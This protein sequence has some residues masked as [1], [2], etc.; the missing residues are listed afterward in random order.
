MLRLWDDKADKV[1]RGDNLR[2]ISPNQEHSYDDDE[3]Y[4]HYVFSKLMFNNPKYKIPEDNLT[5]FKKFL[6][7]GSRSYP[8]DGNIPLDVVSTEA[9]RIIN[10]IVD[11]TSDP[12]HRLYEQ[13]QKTLKNGEYGIVRG[14][15][16]IYL[17]SYTTRDWRRKRFTDDI[18][19]WIHD[20]DLFE[21]VLKKSGWVRNRET[22][23]WEKKVEW[24]DYDSNKKRRGTIIASNDLNL[25]M[26]FNGGSYIDGTSLRDIF[27]KK[28]KRG[29]DVD[30]SDMINVAMLQHDSD[31]GHSTEWK[32]AW[33]A[34]EESANTRDSRIVSNM[35]S[36]CRYAHAI[37][38]YIERVSRSIREYNNLIFD[39][40][41]YPNSELK[42]VCRYSTHWTGY[43]INNGPEATRSMIYSYLVNQQ[44]KKQKYAQNLRNFADKVISVLNSKFQHLK[45]RFEIKD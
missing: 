34:I 16:K 8:S 28:L 37:A 31:N 22:K 2:E 14:C 42:R 23:E 39:K 33:E 13:A 29:H 18:D 6:D 5:L 24:N 27:K 35:I 43:L 41:E 1:V 32:G 21:H 11:I 10:E 38:D 17:K 19:F 7:G 26:D 44:N 15:V 4:T 9:Q 40:S 45:I 30:L 36:L 12:D 3:G 25:R 20:V